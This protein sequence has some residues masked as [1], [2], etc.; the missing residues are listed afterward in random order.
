MIIIYDFDGTLTPNPLP[1][2]PILKKCGYSDDIL[3]NRIKNE[4]NDSH[5]FYE[6]YYKCYID[7]LDE[8]KIVLS[9]SNICY[10]ANKTK[11]NNGVI[12]YFKNYQ[13]SK[14]GIKHYIITSGI[15]YYVDETPI[16]EF[17]DDVFGVTFTQENGL[18][19]SVDMLLSDK[20]KVDIIKKVQYEN[21]NTNE[22]IYFGDGFTDKYAFEYVHSIGGKNVFVA[23]N[24]EAKEIYNK[25]NE[26]GIIDECFDAN[27][28][29]DSSISDYVK[30][31]S[32]SN[33]KN[34]NLESI[35]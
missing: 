26:N 23:L 28:E 6:T 22:I 31:L 1:Q 2:Y 21:N 4:M 30:S 17:V 9:K 8:N 15:K 24:Q 7:I 29:K 12:E 34:K 13:N 3:I 14:T 32:S 20:K 18:F 19:K 16:N 33:F 27:F 11:F 5:D 35:N 10:D 25:L